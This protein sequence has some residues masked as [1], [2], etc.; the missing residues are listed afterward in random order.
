MEP[1]TGSAMLDYKWQRQMSPPE[2]VQYRSARN[3][4]INMARTFFQLLPV[5]NSQYRRASTVVLPPAY[6]PRMPVTQP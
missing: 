2:R 6:Q 3:L 1:F 5:A 4:Q